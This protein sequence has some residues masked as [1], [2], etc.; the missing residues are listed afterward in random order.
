MTRATAR[1]AFSENRVASR[2]VVRSS[3]PVELL[4][5]LSRLP[6]SFVAFVFLNEFASRGRRRR[7]HAPT[8][9]LSPPASS[10]PRGRNTAYTRS[11]STGPTRLSAP[12]APPARIKSF[13]SSRF[14]RSVALASAYARMSASIVGYARTIDSA[15][16]SAHPAIFMSA[17][18]HTSA[19]DFARRAP[20][21][22]LWLSPF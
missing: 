1:A 4:V 12:P 17:P 19:W 14:S 13:K 8:P 21:P 7:A 18:A 15:D 5:Y 11:L 16:A 10:A 9:T 6:S 2:R 3:R 20:P 22:R